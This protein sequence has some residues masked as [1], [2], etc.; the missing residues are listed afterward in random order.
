MPDTPLQWF[1]AGLF[2]AVGALLGYSLPTVV[3]VLLMFIVTFAISI[4]LLDVFQTRGP[5][6]ERRGQKRAPWLWQ[7]PLAGA[8]AG[9]TTFWLSGSTA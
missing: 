8:L 6:L 7:A 2:G 1:Y 9:V 3:T 4:K 5:K